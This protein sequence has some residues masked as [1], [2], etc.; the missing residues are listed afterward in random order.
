MIKREVAVSGGSILGSWR[1]IMGNLRV[2]T[3]SKTHT[4]PEAEALT[5]NLSI[6]SSFGQSP[7]SS[8]QYLAEEAR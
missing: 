4:S 7:S 8:L 3:T 2:P 6:P 5:I 1:L